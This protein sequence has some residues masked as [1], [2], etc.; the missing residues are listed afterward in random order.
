MATNRTLQDVINWASL[1]VASRPLVGQG[2]YVGEPATS[3]A[4]NVLGVILGPP[5]AWRWNRSNYSFPTVVGTQI[6]SQTASTVWWIEQATVSDGT[7]IW[8]LQVRLLIN[9]SL[10][11]GRPEFISIET[12]DNAGNVTY[13]V[14]PIP[15]KIYTIKITFQKVPT[16]FTSLTSTWAPI[17]DEY[18]YIYNS[19]FLAW[20]LESTGDVRFQYEYEKFMRSLVSAADGLTETQKTLFL[21]EKLLEMDN[22]I[23]ATSRAQ[24]PDRGM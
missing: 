11:A 21:K 16:L 14:Y 7:T 4:N 20:C 15:D 6:Y 18:Q 5:F 10:D 13:K 8:P 19:G 12:D 9:D 17:P 2:G 23:S 24:N 1:Y 3:I 22:Q